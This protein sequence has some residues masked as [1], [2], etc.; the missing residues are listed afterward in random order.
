MAN[1]DLAAVYKRNESNRVFV[2]IDKNGTKIYHDYT[3]SRCGGAGGANMWT[4]TG[5]TCYECGG[6]GK[7]RKPHVVKEYTP[8]YRAKLDARAAQRAE[9]R[10]AELEQKKAEEYEAN[11]KSWLADHGFTP[12]GFTY[13]FLG[14]TY[15][16]REQLKESGAKYFTSI[17]WHAD[18]EVD[19][20]LSL[21]IHVDEIAVKTSW[22]YYNVFA[23]E[24]HWKAKKEAAYKQLAGVKESEYVGNVG[25]KVEL[26]LTLV[27]TGFYNGFRGMTT[28]VYTMKDAEGNLFTWKTTSNLERVE[29]GEFIMINK[30]DH[31][32]LKATIKEHSEYKGEKQTVLTRCRVA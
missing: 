20:F 8:E 4:Y 21:K 18:H 32:T 23:T 17:G 1:V 28:A 25:D 22:G 11:G 10:K 9:K 16:A 31:F 13:I 29:N 5:W 6:T 24:E 19:G 12:D 26:E 15:E 27:R 14:D 30:G 2:R 3:C 7:S